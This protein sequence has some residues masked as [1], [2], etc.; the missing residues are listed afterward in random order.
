MEANDRGLVRFTALAHALF[1]TYEL[2]I[3]LFVGLW[4]AEFGVSAAVI[5]LVVGAGYGLVGIGALPS[6]ILADRLESRRLILLS[7]VGMGASFLL[8]SLARGVVTLGVAVVVWGAF[9]SLYHPCGLSLISRSAEERGTVFAY[10]GAGGNVGTAAGPLVTA[11]LLL[12]VEWR[13]AVALL[14]LPAF[15]AA[16]VGSRIQFESVA[17]AGVGE[18]VG[19][20]VG[21]EVGEAI[22]EEVGE[23][24]DENS[25]TSSEGSAGTL[26]DDLRRTAADTRSLFGLGFSVAFV[27]VLLYGTY[28]RGLLTFLPDVLAGSTALAPIDVLG[29]EV[30]PSQHVYSALLAVGI[31]GQYAGGRLTDRLPSTTAFTGSLGVLVALA[32]LF[33]VASSVGVVPLV[34]VSLALGFFVY[35]TAPIYQVV[36][37]EQAADDVHGLSY[38]YTY[39]AMFGIGALGASMAGA[40]L[41]YA[42]SSTLFVALAAI[43]AAGVG[44]A[45]LLRRLA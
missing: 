42:T 5:G 7:V 37:A 4:M 8:V 21:E 43:A 29:R 28:Y 26:R 14:A 13:V 1:H 40:V 39:L 24:V 16:F 2:S 31:G 34:A 20:E 38:G 25:D 41:T 30:N 23:G 19:K 36:I 11:L 17:A 32:L 45:L 12:A 10:H 9:A 6:G 15:V 35:G 18:E 44:C 27:A 22:G 3:P 33:P